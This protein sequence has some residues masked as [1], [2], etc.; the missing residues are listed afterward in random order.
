MEYFA[1]IGLHAIIGN[2][3]DLAEKALNPYRQ[4]RV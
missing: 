3:P 4:M 2:F 1:R